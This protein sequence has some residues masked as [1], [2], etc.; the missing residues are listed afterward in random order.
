MD[1]K[2]EAAEQAYLDA[3]YD[4]VSREDLAARVRAAPDMGGTLLV[5]LGEFM[6]AAHEVEFA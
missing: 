3:C 1:E 2:F 5:Q 6:A 4:N